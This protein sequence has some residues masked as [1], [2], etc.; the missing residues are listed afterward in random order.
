MSK[1]KGAR[2]AAGLS[3]EK[4][5]EMA[6]TSQPQIL[7]LEKG[8]RKMT[9]DWA[10]RLAPHLGV[11]PSELLSLEGFTPDFVAVSPDG[12]TVIGEV[13]RHSGRGYKKSP[14]EA[15][16]VPRQMPVRAAARGGVDQEMFLE[17]GPIDWVTIPDYLK[18]ARDPY[19]IWVV[20]ES[21]MPRFRPAQ[22]LHIN[23][24]KP[25]MAGA[26]VVVV[27]KS[28]AV[29]IK[30]FVRHT[31]DGDLV[32]REYNPEDREFTVPRGD[33]ATVHTVVGLQE[34]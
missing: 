33:L 26:G 10:V 34:P 11:H 23:P 9:L 28:K 15:S 6:G 32:L 19:G 8:E 1:L 21:M 16:S 3:Q 17:D 25:P 18:N 14:I 13:K 31:L 29:L 24:F 20:G 4:L 5:A 22:I 2:M 12:N 7:K 30:E 27:K